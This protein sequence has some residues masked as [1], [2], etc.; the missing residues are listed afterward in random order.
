MI[1]LIKSASWNKEKNSF[2]FILKIGYTKD[3][4]AQNRFSSYVNHNP[5][6]EILFKIPNATREQE[7]LLHKYF[8]GFRIHGNEW[9]EYREE[10]I[11]FFTS[12]TTKDSFV[13]FYKNIKQIRDTLVARFGIDYDMF[14]KTN[15]FSE[16]IFTF[17]RK[18][19][20]NYSDKYVAEVFVKFLKDFRKDKIP[21]IFNV[22]GCKRKE[23]RKIT[24]HEQFYWFIGKEGI[25]LD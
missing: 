15:E 4:S 17:W 24:F 25:E 2:E 21:K 22:I 20:V 10:I 5:T 16:E 12:H 14:I 23:I 3:S 7:S 11:N 18:L 8:K 1:Y 19:Q 9:Y 13:A 6:V